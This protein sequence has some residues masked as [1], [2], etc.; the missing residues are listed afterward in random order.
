MV[1]CAPAPNHGLL[2]AHQESS[3]VC[4]L[5]TG[6]PGPKDGWTQAQRKQQLKA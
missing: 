6:F 4:Q 1:V 3:Y 2:D 5:L